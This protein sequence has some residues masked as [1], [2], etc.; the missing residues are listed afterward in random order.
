MQLP[1]KRVELVPAKRRALILEHLRAHGPASIQQL[2]EVIGGSQ[3]TVRRDLEHL[4]E[5]GYLERTHGGALLIPPARAAFEGEFSLHQAMCRMQKRC[6][7]V[8]AADRLSPRQS[9]ICDSSSTVLETISVVA[10]RA[11]PLTVVTNSLEIA[12]VSAGVPSWRVIVPG[13][14]VRPG[15][16]MLA[17]PPGE[18]FF[19]GIHADVCLIG[20]LAVSGSVLTDATIEVA[21]LKRAMM[22]SAERRILLVDST[23]FRAPCFSAFGDLSEI[24]EVITDDGIAPEH[25]DALAAVDVKVT[26]VP[27]VDEVEHLTA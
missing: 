16:T 20:A 12:L 21:A 4:T 1:P 10:R 7:G 2:A 18:A 11:M 17:G 6:I 26:V 9:I 27:V 14:T 24:D 15:S 22:R 25:L 5:A 13:G 3:S 23:K 8:E 19:A